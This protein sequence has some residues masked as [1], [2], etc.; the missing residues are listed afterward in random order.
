MRKAYK[1]TIGNKVFYF[2]KK[3]VT[4]HKLK[5]EKGWL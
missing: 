5:K 3:A 2:V 4:I 1:G